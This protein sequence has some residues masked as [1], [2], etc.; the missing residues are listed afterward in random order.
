[1]GPPPPG[2]YRPHPPGG[3]SQPG[4][5]PGGYAPA[6]SRSRRRWPWVVAGVVGLV[7]AV[8]GVGLF[9]G[10]FTTHVLDQ[11]A[12]QRGVHDIL[13]AE[14]GL[15][16]GAVSCPADSEITRGNVFTCTADL[17]GRDVAVKVTVVSDQGTYE[18]DN[19]VD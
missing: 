13:T 16:V 1:M 2:P 7:A 19:P 11:Q 4:Y 8:A 15:K 17:D 12:V 14:Y 5:P 6:R 10:W 3:Y 18:V 9:A